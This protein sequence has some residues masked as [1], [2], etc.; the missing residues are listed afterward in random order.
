MSR[1][2]GEALSL[3]NPFSPTAVAWTAHQDADESTI[4]TVRTSAIDAA[5]RQLDIYLTAS[6]E[7]E[8]AAAP[9]T[10]RGNV[11]VV[12]GDH[13]TGKTHLAMQ[14]LAHALLD[15]PKD[16]HVVYVEAGST[17]FL[18][19][20]QRFVRQLELSDMLGR[21]REFYRD[22]V[23]D[24]L[25]SDP[26]TA[27]VAGFLR[28]ERELDIGAVVAEIG[29]DDRTLVEPFERKLGE[30]TTNPTLIT[31][32]S[33]LLR[34]GFQNSVWAWL[35][36]ELPAEILRERGIE[37][38]I[39]T[40]TGALEAMA[41]IALLYGRHNH[42]LIVVVDEIDRVLFGTGRPIDIVLAP[43][44]TMLAA[45]GEAGALL[46]LAGLP[47]FLRVLPDDVQQRIGRTIRMP[48][49]TD[50]E[51]RQ[52][53]VR[54]LRATEPPELGPFTEGA[55]PYIRSLTGGVPRKIIKLC[56][57]L[58]QEAA[59]EQVEV[60]VGLVREVAATQDLVV[61]SDDVR[62]QVRVLLG[63]EGVAHSSNYLL[64][65]EVPLARV[66][67]WVQ[68][69]GEAGF[70]LLVTDSVLEADEIDGL[71]ERA[72][73]IQ[74]A[75]PQTEVLLVVV[76]YIEDQTAAEMAGYLNQEP[77]RYEGRTFPQNL[78]ATVRAMAI[79]AGGAEAAAGTGAARSEVARLAR[80][81]SNLYLFI[82][83]L[84]KRLDDMRLSNEQHFSSVREQ[85]GGVTSAL[86]TGSTPPGQS[87]RGQPTDV[88]GRLPAR[89]NRLFVT[90]MDALSDLRRVDI[91]LRQVFT[92][93]TG[94]ETAAYRR[95]I[96]QLRA[97]L[98]APRAM[99]AVS[100]VTLLQR[101]V[102][103]FRES[104]ADWYRGL[105]PDSSGRILPSDEQQLRA[106]CG[107]YDAVYEYLPAF[108]I[109]GLSEFAEAYAASGDPEPRSRGVDI[110]DVLDGLAARVQ[111]TMLEVIS[112]PQ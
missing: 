22:V 36:G 72:L 103:I 29:V 16:T 85:L 91:A 60:T 42:R 24:R 95:S 39:S 47:E 37:A 55:V 69:D 106:L 52:L 13:G 70:G 67:E 18:Q 45:F 53:I 25:G 49:M 11:V 83:Q 61:T 8:S 108:E 112:S 62:R 9:A 57:H 105:N 2:A 23:L 21:V 7:L 12:V 64:S 6:R 68:V 73:A 35:R 56:E 84:G 101:L 92:L 48:P 107:A 71:R 98:R 26:L 93:S 97:A 99:P 74:A 46:V 5:L 20:Y 10:M 77:L 76:G 28:S 43:F 3:L 4:V 86:T 17:D 30:I 104:V 89:V 33:L 44:K 58:Y 38:E 40:E 66:D 88:P 75:R 109:R 31:A 65:V 19:L 59:T 50:E 54:T 78:T 102:T 81:Q 15:R 110:R 96:S 14:V 41:V 100:A 34:P 32:F 79:R 111:R 1:P 80:Q 63:A 94:T 27:A 82:D 90:A 51:T 87:A